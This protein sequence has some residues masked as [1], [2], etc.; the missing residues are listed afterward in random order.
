MSELALWEYIAASLEQRTDGHRK[1]RQK[2]R[3]AFTT[4]DADGDGLLDVDEFAGGI[5]ALGCELHKTQMGSLF[6]SMDSNE[7]GK[8]SFPEFQ[9]RLFEVFS[10]REKYFHDAKSHFVGKHHGQQSP[11]I[12]TK[13]HTAASLAAMLFLGGIANR[14]VVREEAERR[15]HGTHCP[16]A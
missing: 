8:I 4:M 6:R 5:R 9:S 13:L 15:A 3:R 1:Q 10:K 2:L 12:P 16:S 14:A 7:D 11:Q